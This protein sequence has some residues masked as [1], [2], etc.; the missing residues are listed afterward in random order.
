MVMVNV[1]VMRMLLGVIAVDISILVI[2]SIG[3]AAIASYYHPN[4]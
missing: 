4:R 3:S 2:I 1:L